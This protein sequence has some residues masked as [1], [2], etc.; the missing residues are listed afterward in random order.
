MEY[1][2]GI[3]HHIVGN[4]NIGYIHDEIQNLIIEAKKNNKSMTEID[5]CVKIIVYSNPNEESMDKFF[6]DAIEEMLLY[7]ENNELGTIFSDYSSTIYK[8]VP[9][10]FSD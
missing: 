4:S 8:L 5:N 9:Q 10:F 2:Y 6:P 7:I 3:K 1:E